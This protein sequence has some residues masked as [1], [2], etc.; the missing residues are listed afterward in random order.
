MTNI[1]FFFNLGTCEDEHARCPHWSG[2]GECSANPGWMLNHCKKS[3]NQ[4]CWGGGKFY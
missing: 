4:T 3:C 1:D 2:I